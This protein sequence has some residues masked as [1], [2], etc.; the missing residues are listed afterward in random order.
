MGGQLLALLHQGGVHP[1]LRQLAGLGHHGLPNKVCSFSA[2]TACA[3]LWKVAVAGLLRQRV[4]SSME[5]FMAAT[6]RS[7]QQAVGAHA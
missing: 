2:I 5:Q 6:A 7:G 3:W 1:L 4:H